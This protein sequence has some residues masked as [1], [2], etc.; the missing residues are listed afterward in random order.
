MAEWYGGSMSLSNSCFSSNVGQ[1]AGSVFIDGDSISIDENNFQDS[2]DATNNSCAGVFLSQYVESDGAPPGV[3]RD[4]DAASCLAEAAPSPAPTVSPTLPPR[5]SGGEIDDGECIDSWDKLSAAIGSSNDTEATVFTLCTEQAINVT[6]DAI[7]VRKNLFLECGPNG[8]LRNNCLLSGGIRHFKLLGEGIDV[9]FRGITFEGSSDVSVLAAADRESNAR[10]EECQWTGN[11]G[12]T[13][14]LVYNEAAGQEYARDTAI[15]SLPLTGT[16]MSVSF[17]DCIFKSNPAT[18]SI[19]SNIGGKTTFSFTAFE[20]NGETFMASI[21]A[22]NYADLDI[23]SSCFIQNDS[24]L[25]GTVFLST[26]SRIQFEDNYGYDNRV[27]FPFRCTDIFTLAEDENCSTT[28]CPGLCS[29]FDAKR[30]RISGYE[31][32]APSSAPSEFIPVKPTIPGQPNEDSLYLEKTSLLTSGFIAQNLLIAAIICVSGFVSF[33][34]CKSK[35]G[36]RS[37]PLKNE[38]SPAMM[39]ESAP[40]R[41]PEVIERFE[42]DEMMNAG[43]VV[44]DPNSRKKENTKQKGKL[45]GFFGQRNNNAVVRQEEFEP[46]VHTH[47]AWPVQRSDGLQD[48]DEDEFHD[49][50]DDE[51]YADGS[52]KGDHSDSGNEIELT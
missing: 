15:D 38:S 21:V 49:E 4:F 43:P 24:N 18:H 40:L 42:D 31:F 26:A 8:R 27:G 50:I 46:I 23:T 20:N 14:V 6:D 11:A 1:F 12:Q 28:S 25:S 2:N 16:S 32:D 5:E 35:Q 9:S 22:R 51:E 33:F 48:D 45:G 3:C 19:V 44:L 39:A 41:S 17:Q 13:V 10:F 37:V 47:D 29:T 36:R 7:V 34:Y 30:C 52:D